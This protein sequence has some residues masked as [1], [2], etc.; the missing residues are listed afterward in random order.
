MVHR[1]VWPLCTFAYAVNR[2]SAQRILAEFD[3][4]E[5]GK[6]TPAY[7]VRILEACRDLGWL[8]YSVT[9]ELFHHND[10]P[11]EIAEL[12]GEASSEDGRSPRDSGA[13]NIA[14]GA[15]SE[16]LFTKDPDT[17]TYLRTQISSKGECL[18]DQTQQRM[19]E[20]P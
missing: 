17:L 2:V 10:G 15:R 19:G 20:W 18:I 6:G 12:N 5:E 14:C 16:E 9:P 8:C 13:P 11:S 7:D 3:R 1:S 4:E